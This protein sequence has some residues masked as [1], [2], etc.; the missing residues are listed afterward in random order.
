MN[1]EELRWKIELQA[2]KLLGDKWDKLSAK[3]KW[4]LVEHTIQKAIQK[5]KEESKL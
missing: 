1:M 3:E 2:R 4:D 5:A